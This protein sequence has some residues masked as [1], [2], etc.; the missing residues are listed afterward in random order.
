L[1]GTINRSFA[2]QTFGLADAQQAGVS[3]LMK[4][5][6]MLVLAYVALITVT[7]AAEINDDRRTQEY[8]HPNEHDALRLT[9]GSE[10]IA[11]IASMINEVEDRRRRVVYTAYPALPSRGVQHGFVHVSDG[12]VAFARTDLVVNAAMPILIKRSYLSS[13]TVDENFGSAGWRLTLFEEIRPSN[14]GDNYVYV[15]GNNQGVVVRRDGTINQPTLA[16]MLDIAEFKVTP[17]SHAKVTLRSGIT[18][19]FKKEGTRFLLSNVT[20][21]NGHSQKYSYDN[22]YLTGIRTSDGASVR[23]ARDDFGRI[24]AIE[25]YLGRFVKYSYDDDDLLRHV[26]DLRS[27][28]WSYEYDFDR[29]VTQAR[30]PMGSADLEFRYNAAK[31][32]ELANVNGYRFEYRYDGNNTHVKDENGRETVFAANADGITFRVLSSL[33][34]I[35]EIVFDE[36]GRP[37]KLVRNGTALSEISYGS[38]VQSR[39]PDEQRMRSAAN[40]DQEFVI[41]FDEIGRVH[42]VQS[43]DIGEA[44][45]VR[46][47]GD[48][49]FPE[50][51]EYDDKTIALARVDKDG[52]LEAYRSKR[53]LEIRL[54]WDG[55]EA[56]AMAGKRS[57][58]LVFDGPGRLATLYMADGSIARFTYDSGGLRTSMRVADGVAVDYFYDSSG[59]LFYTEAG[60]DENSK[61]SFVYEID[62]YQRLSSIGGSAVRGHHDFDYNLAGRLIRVDSTI[63]NNMSFLYDDA[64]RLEAVL[65][66][67]REPIQYTYDDGEPDVIAQLDSRTRAIFNQQF[68]MTEF[69]NRFSV[70]YT[71]VMPSTLGVLNYN[72]RLAELT[73]SIDPARWSPHEFVD[74]AVANTKLVHLLEPMD[75][76]LQSFSM[77]SNRFF[78]PAE[79]W[80]VNCCFCCPNNSI[81]CQ[82]P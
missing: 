17:G 23:F 14:T 69:S 68:E 4:K 5:V 39:F 66:D 60:F 16:T 55:A 45:E 58:K 49:F 50:R 25:D 80:S 51:V 43:R 73:T 8:G 75:N 56:L 22:G 62:Q 32:A 78:I 65:A 9:K 11:R 46:R 36:Q 42:R 48:G 38:E 81:S 70:L 35:T 6:Q 82:I 21:S 28:M 1:P 77:P 18:K 31:K 64:G 12:A 24:T 7:A 67:G 26:T 59:S 61:E 40:E 34:T 71:R 54:R 10:E 15:Y 2:K 19:H 57:V 3:P 79:Y 41:K 76:G 63:T 52:N 13:R 72:D 53:G 27:E 33:G 20:D 74:S 44:Y 37:G 47:Y 30:S 29:M